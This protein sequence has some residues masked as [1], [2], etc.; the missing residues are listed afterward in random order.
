ML[1]FYALRIFNSVWKQELFW[2]LILVEMKLKDHDV[3]SV[4]LRATVTE[5]FYD[6]FEENWKIIIIGP[7][8]KGLSLDVCVLYQTRNNA[9]RS[10]EANEEDNGVESSALFVDV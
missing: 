3:A 8:K 7:A 9:G 10:A 4:I 6:I 5:L 2:L 1:F